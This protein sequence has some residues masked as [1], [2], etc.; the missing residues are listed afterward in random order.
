M[1]RN[2]Y[3]PRPEDLIVGFLAQ[4][5]PKPTDKPEDHVSTPFTIFM[6]QQ[7]NLVLRDLAKTRHEITQL[8]QK[9]QRQKRAYRDLQRAHTELLRLRMID[10]ASWLR[11][12][13]P[14][15]QVIETGTDPFP[16]VIEE[17]TGPTIKNIRTGEAT[18]YAPTRPHS[19]PDRNTEDPEPPTDP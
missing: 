15:S 13:V 10:K 14:W 12:G 2:A 19:K 16:T 6:V 9:S 1:K 11:P 18:P 3:L 4:L 17:Y 7:I 8:R 5:K